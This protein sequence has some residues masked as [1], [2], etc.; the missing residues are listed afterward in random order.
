MGRTLVGSARS[1][2]GL[3]EPNRKKS[4]EEEG[5]WLV[6]RLIK[7][8][9][10]SSSGIWRHGV[11]SNREDQGTSAT[12]QGRASLQV[13]IGTSPQIGIDCP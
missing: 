13:R 7:A 4:V 6:F 10:E 12:F 1:E 11:R 2:Q 5:L 9:K 8:E 3:E